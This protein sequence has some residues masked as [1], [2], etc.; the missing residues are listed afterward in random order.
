VESWGICWCHSYCN[1]GNNNID[2]RSRSNWRSATI[3]IGDELSQV[4]G[5]TNVAGVVVGVVG[6]VAVGAAFVAAAIYRPASIN[7]ASYCAAATVV[8]GCVA[9]IASSI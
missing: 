8:V 4:N 7:N 6:L 2:R 1:W 3:A 9:L 5:G